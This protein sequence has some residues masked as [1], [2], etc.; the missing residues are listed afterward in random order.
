MVQDSDRPSNQGS[1]THP[2]HRVPSCRTGHTRS[3]TQTLAW[4]LLRRGTVF[5]SERRGCWKYS[6]STARSF[7][8]Q[9]HN[10][11]PHYCGAS[12]GFPW[13]LPEDEKQRCF[14]VSSWL[15]LSFHIHVGCV[16]KTKLGTPLLPLVTRVWQR[17]RGQVQEL[18]GRC[19]CEMGT[20]TLSH[21]GTC[22]LEI[23]IP[24]TTALTLPH[25]TSLL[26]ARGED[27]C[28]VRQKFTHIPC[29]FLSGW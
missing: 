9:S 13:W 12:W 29:W 16:F 18:P 24:D 1:A 17:L 8:Q 26:G 23:P 15:A 11:I 25:V 5:T 6:C 19:S 2:G 22:L 3:L 10:E 27:E 21:R 20:G 14:F 28:M 4:V 7:S